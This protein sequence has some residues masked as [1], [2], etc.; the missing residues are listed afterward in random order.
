MLP[1]QSKPDKVLTWPSDPGLQGLV[2]NLTDPKFGFEIT[3]TVFYSPVTPG[4]KSKSA[5]MFHHGH[6]NCVCPMAKGDPVIKGAKCR[7]GC[8]SSMPSLAENSDPGYSWW[9]LYN[10]SN[11]YHSLGHDVFILSM[12]L[13][14]INLGPGTTD[15]YLATDHWWFLQWEEKGDS[16]LRYF[17][18]PAVLTMNFAK[19]QGYGDVYMAGLSGGGWSTTFA[20]AIDKRIKGSFP[21]AGSVPC[22]MRNPLGTFPGQQWTGD[23]D[24]DYEQSCM[25]TNAKKGRPLGDQNPG[26]SAFNACNYT[27]QYLLAGLEP[28]RFQVQILHEYDTCCF[29]PHNRHDQM[30]Q[31]EANIRAELMAQEGQTGWFTSAAVN[32]SKHEVAAQGKT[33]MA[34]AVAGGWARGAPDW[35]KIPCDMMHQPLPANCAMNVDPGLPP[36][37]VPQCP[38]ANG[39]RADCKNITHGP[40]GVSMFSKFSSVDDYFSSP[41]QR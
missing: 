7:P 30:L 33:I 21:I 20:S 41:G 6:S 35:Q 36:G 23:D 29:S 39:K 17:L 9:D 8:N 28:E 13:K 38:A 1:T 11:F 26:R 3:S 16:P 25:P 32:H 40:G 10:V 12:P 15:K 31:Y 14:G 27:C 34:A 24:E 37:Y 18:E 22:A 2:W 4:K 19:A 5:F